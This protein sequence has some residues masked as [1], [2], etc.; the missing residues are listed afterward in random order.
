[1]NAKHQELLEMK[2]TNFDLDEWAK[3]PGNRRELPE[4]SDTSIRK[5]Q[6]F[7]S[8]YSFNA[9]Y[10]EAQQGQDTIFKATLSSDRPY[11]RHFGFEILDHTSQAINLERANGD[12]LPLLWGHDQSE[13]IGRVA[14]VNINDGKLHGKLIFGSSERAQA[15]KKDIEN[16]IIRNMSI[17]YLIDEFD[18]IEADRSQSGEPTYQVKKWT[19]LEASVVSVPADP[20]VGIGRRGVDT[21][22]NPA[23]K[24]SFDKRATRAFTSL[25]EARK[26]I[27][28]ESKEG[29]EFLKEV[30]ATCERYA[31][32]IN[33]PFSELNRIDEIVAS[34]AK[35]N[36][37]SK[38]L[39][40]IRNNT[41]PNDFI[42]EVLEK[43]GNTKLEKSDDSIFQI[44]A[45]EMKKYSLLRVLQHLNGDKRADVGYE[46][47]VSQELERRSGKHSNGIIVPFGALQ[48]RAVMDTSGSSGNLVQTDVFDSAFIDFIRPHS[49]LAKLGVTTL[50]GLHGQ[51]D[52]PRKTGTTS[53]GWAD[54]NGTYSIPDSEMTFDQVSLRMKSLAG[55][56]HISHK[57]LKQS[58]IDIEHQVRYDLAL[59]IANEF[60]KAALIGDGTGN[61]P[62]GIINQAGIA[63]DTYTTAPTW[64]NIVNMEGLIAANSADT[65]TMSYITTPTLASNLKSI[66]KSNGSGQYIWE[67]GREPGVGRMNNLGAHYTANMPADS[68]L[69]GNWR[70]LIVGTW[71][72]LELMA[73]PYGS[74]FSKG[75]V[76]VRA[77]LDTD[78]QVRHPKSFCLSTLAVA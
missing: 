14:D 10:R 51:V 77:I 32:D 58:S 17:G 11:Y 31:Q 35:H 44:G 49:I 73:D 62:V 22:D 29:A 37:T 55:L 15:I 63:S 71:G 13:Q 69:L 40:A 45:N 43:S 66:E 19:L 56:S 65:K 25:Q 59:T 33:V 68:I 4:I 8:P 5:G 78:I 50:S 23:S 3:Q 48:E 20:S 39:E 38:G 53:A 60:D 28:S 76:S 7:E 74:N 21:G 30:K 52:I 54:L 16:G 61:T 67:N 64:S 46:M 6:R 34:S 26:L 70:D 2:N 57:L 41:N 24:T 1:M 72:G 42:R 27:P 47:E 18:F 75:V 36:C 12:S 9:E